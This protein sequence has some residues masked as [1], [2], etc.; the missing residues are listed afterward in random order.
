MADIPV[1][2]G[3]EH[4]P[5]VGTGIGMQEI[6]KTTAV[7]RPTRGLKDISVLDIFFNRNSPYATNGAATANH[8]AA[9]L[10]GSNPSE[11]CIASALPG[12]Q[13]RNTAINA[14]REGEYLIVC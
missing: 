14:M 2:Q 5:A 4:V 1:P 9:Q 7:M 12:K 3:W 10:K 11:M 8:N 13:M 6:M